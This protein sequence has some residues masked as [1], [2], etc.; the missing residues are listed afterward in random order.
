MKKNNRKS[1]TTGI[2]T[3]KHIEKC[4]I[5][6]VD[7]GL[8]RFIPE[9]GVTPLEFIRLP[10]EQ[11]IKQEKPDK[12]L[13]KGLI[14]I[15]VSK[16]VL[17]ARVLHHIGLFTARELLPI[18]ENELPDDSRLRRAIGIKERW[19]KAGM[20][21]GKNDKDLSAAIESAG[22]AYTDTWRSWRTWSGISMEARR[23]AE[24]IQKSLDKNPNQAASIA[25]GKVSARF[26]KKIYAYLCE[27]IET[28]SQA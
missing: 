11:I 14:N 2:V 24:A 27:L 13:H 25:P 15:L 7:A 19:I 18:Y 28:E 17:P 16:N 22:A 20:K 3:W 6:P 8:A 9:S 4:G 12:S 26:H 1:R 5:N 10:I 23:A 21:R